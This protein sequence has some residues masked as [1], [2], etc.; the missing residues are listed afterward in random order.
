MSDVHSPSVRSANMRAIK[1]RGTSLELGVRKALFSRGLR[2]RVNVRD[3][4]ARP[5]IVFPKY[6]AIIFI[7]GC[8]WHGHNCDLFKIPKT[9]TEFWLN[10]ISGTIGR[11]QDSHQ[12][13]MGLGWRV[14]VI[15]ECALKGRGKLP[16]NECIDL[17]EEWILDRRAPGIELAGEVPID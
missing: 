12:K 6:K 5:D 1:H 7:N 16:F 2:Y 4:P 3:L 15:W 8:F 10:K 17:L 9:R 11:D 14:G 13:L